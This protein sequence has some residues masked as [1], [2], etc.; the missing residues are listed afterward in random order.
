MKKKI[1]ILATLSINRNKI[2]NLLYQISII[3]FLAGV[4]N[5]NL[6]SKSKRRD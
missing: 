4:T 5:Q 6:T 3:V 2:V 1:D